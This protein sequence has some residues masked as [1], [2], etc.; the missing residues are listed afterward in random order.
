MDL[1]TTVG[2]RSE[3]YPRDPRSILQSFCDWETIRGENFEE[4]ARRNGS[5]HE[6]SKRLI[7][8]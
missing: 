8:C 5:M 4:S 1:R 6:I 2:L 3:A 7:I